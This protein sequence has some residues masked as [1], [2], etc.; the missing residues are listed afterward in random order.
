LS[1]LQGST[2]QADDWGQVLGKEI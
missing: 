2:A 1:D